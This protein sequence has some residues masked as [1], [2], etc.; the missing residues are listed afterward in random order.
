MKI[1]EKKE[2]ERER[3]KER[4]RERK[5]ERS[6]LGGPGKLDVLGLYFFSYVFYVSSR[7]WQLFFIVLG[8]ITVVNPCPIQG[9]IGQFP[10]VTH[11]LDGLM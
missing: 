3:E 6:G 1:L 8:K 9:L 2:R 4:E 7:F 5:R 10:P 11:F